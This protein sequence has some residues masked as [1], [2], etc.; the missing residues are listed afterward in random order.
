MR[1]SAIENVVIDLC[2][3]SQPPSWRHPRSVEE[4]RAFDRAAPATRMRNLRNGHR[5][6]PEPRAPDD[7]RHGVTA[8]ERELRRLEDNAAI[9][10]GEAARL[11]T[12]DHDA[13]NSKLASKR[14]ALGFEIY[15]AGEA[16]ELVRKFARL[17]LLRHQ[18][19]E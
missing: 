17:G 4:Q 10:V 12:R 18:L 3:A 16:F 11:C 15:R 6:A 14:F 5:V 13:A 7:T 9:A 8:H 2:D 1:S 19:C